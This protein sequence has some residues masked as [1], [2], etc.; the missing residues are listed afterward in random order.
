[1]F[2]YVELRLKSSENIITMFDDK[3]KFRE[4]EWFLYRQQLWNQRANLIRHLGPYLCLIKAFKFYK[5][6]FGLWRHCGL[7]WATMWRRLQG[8]RSR[9]QLPPW[10]HRWVSP[11]RRSRW[12]IPKW[13]TFWDW[14]INKEKIVKFE[15]DWNVV[16]LNL[17]PDKLTKV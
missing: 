10:R 12:W 8:R 13:E 17:L 6:E 14:K 3:V 9:R 11:G 2:F 1:M 4:L 5:I 15:T 16:G 7:P